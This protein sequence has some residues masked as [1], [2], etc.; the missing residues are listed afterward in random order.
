MADLCR[1]CGGDTRRPSP[2]ELLRRFPRHR[3]V[4]FSARCCFNPMKLRIPPRLLV[5]A[6]RWCAG[7]DF[8][9]QAQAV[10]SA[11]RWCAG[12]AA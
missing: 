1:R 12:G 11:L 4:L 8:L 2:L 6:M 3:E 7:G 10:E 9:T 5:R